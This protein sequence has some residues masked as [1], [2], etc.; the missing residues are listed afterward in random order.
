MEN[1]KVLQQASEIRVSGKKIWQ[2]VMHLIQTSYVIIHTYKDLEG[3]PEIYN[4]RDNCEGV[5]F[6]EAIPSSFNCFFVE[7]GNKR[8][9]AQCMLGHLTSLASWSL[10]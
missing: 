9:R 6:F 10:F 2:P 1:L 5:D 4:N 7:Y 3:V 8:C